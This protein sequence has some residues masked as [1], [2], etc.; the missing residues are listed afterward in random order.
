M[1]PHPIV[2][3][4]N[5]IY[6]TIRSHQERHFPARVSGTKLVNP[7]FT[8]WAKSFG[9]EAFTLQMGDDVEAVVAAF[10]SAKGAAVLHVKSSKVAL[11]AGG[12]LKRD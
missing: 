9:A 12:V 6:G 4:D 3:S 10:L 11:S 5:G 1:V 7:D 2:I 8:V